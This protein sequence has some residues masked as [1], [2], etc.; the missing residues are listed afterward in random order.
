MIPTQQVG[1]VGLQV[2]TAHYHIT[3]G[4]SKQMTTDYRVAVRSGAPQT[5]PAVIGFAQVASTGGPYPPVVTAKFLKN[6]NE[7]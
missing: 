2:P 7:I 6:S 1:H 5:A 3:F 4:I